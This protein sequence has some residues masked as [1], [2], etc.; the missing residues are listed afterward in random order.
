MSEHLSKRDILKFIEDVAKDYEADI[1]RNKAA[2]FRIKTRIAEHE[3]YAALH[4]LRNIGI[5]PG[6]TLFR[7]VIH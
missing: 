1:N 7:T 3:M 5:F 2:G 6:K 4:I